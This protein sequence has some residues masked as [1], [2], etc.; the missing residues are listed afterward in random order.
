MAQ[1]FRIMA[2]VLAM[3]LLLA[4]CRSARDSSHSSID[5]PDAH[6]APFV[7]DHGGIV[8]GD[9]TRKRLALIFTGGDFG[10]GAGHILDTLRDRRLRASF[11]VTGAYLANPDHE[12]GLRRIIAEG[13]YLGPHSHAHPLYCP[14]EG[15]ARSLVTERAFNADL[16]RNLREIRAIGGLTKGEPVFFVP[17]YEWFNDQHVAWAREVGAVLVNFTPGSGSNRDYVPE[18]EPGFVPSMRIVADI[19]AY[20]AKDAHGLNGFLLLLHMGS[21]R[22]DKVYLHLGR[23]IDELAARGYTF[24]RVDELLRS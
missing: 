17:P 18:G 4:G 24:V 8:R 16:R 14:W 3:A 15:R 1:A 2:C 21:R 6:A 7:L 12:H 9:V 19:L 22:E 5:H 23:L 10:D 13:H 20:E 11:F